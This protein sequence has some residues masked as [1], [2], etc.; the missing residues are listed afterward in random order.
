ML[1]GT[2]V[3]VEEGLFKAIALVWGDVPEPASHEMMALRTWVLATQS[4]ACNSK[5]MCKE[6]WSPS[7][8][9]RRPLMVP[10]LHSTAPLS[11]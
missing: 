3:A 2:L 11:G 5:D 7:P 9:R 8:R 10:A 1:T 6:A 4:G